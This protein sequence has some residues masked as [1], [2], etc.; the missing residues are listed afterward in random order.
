M[1]T[2]AS[3]PPVPWQRRWA[4]QRGSRWSRMLVRTPRRAQTTYENEMCAR[5]K[6]ET[7]FYCFNNLSCVLHSISAGFYLKWEFPLVRRVASIQFPTRVL[8]V[9]DCTILLRL[10]WRSVGNLLDKYY[11]NLQLLLF[12]NVIRSTFRIIT[13]TMFVTGNLMLRSNIDECFALVKMIT[14]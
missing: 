13:S 6:R 9:P 4:P 2:L 1:N 5:D 8:C 3:S 14:L 12:K 11:H 7:I 10:L